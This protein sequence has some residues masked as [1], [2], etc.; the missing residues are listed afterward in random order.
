MKRLGFT[1]TA[2]SLGIGLAALLILGVG[3]SAA[4]ADDVEATP[5]T[6]L[7]AADGGP[8]GTAAVTTTFMVAGGELHSC[9]ITDQGGALQC[10]G[11]NGLGQ[12]GD[13]STDQHEAPVGVNGLSS[14]IR[15]VDGGYDHSCAVTTGGGVKCWGNNSTGQ[16]GNGYW[17]QSLVPVDVL[18]DD[19]STLG[20]AVAVGTGD[21]HSCA[22][23]GNGQVR[24]WGWNA[25]GQLGDNSF[26]NRGKA[27][28]VTTTTGSP[29]TSIQ[30]IDLGDVHSCALTTGGGVKC[31]GNGKYGKLGDGD[32]GVHYKMTPVDVIGLSG[33]ATISAGFD[34]TC[35]VLTDTTARCW[36]GNGSGQLGN[37]LVNTYCITPQ[38]VSG[39]TKG[40]AIAAGS[41]HTCA[42]LS[43]G[44]AKCWGNNLYGQLGDNRASGATSNVP[45]DVSGI[46][47]G[48]TALAIGLG[49]DHSC[50]I[51]EGWGVKCWGYNSNGQLGDDSDDNRNTPVNVDGLG[52]YKI[53]GSVLGCAGSGHATVSNGAGHTISCGATLCGYTFEDLASAAYT[54]TV[55]QAGYTYYPSQEVVDL[56]P[57][58]SDIDFTCWATAT[59]SGQVID[60]QGKAIPGVTMSCGSSP[61]TTT[62]S[63]GSFSFGVGYGSLGTLCELT[64]SRPGYRFSPA[65]RTVTVPPDSSGNDFQ[66]STSGP[67]YSISGQV[68]DGDGNPLGLVTVT[69]GG[70][71]PATSDGN[72]NYSL[73]TLVTGT[74]TF[75][76]TKTGFTFS[77]GSRSAGL[78]PDQSGQDFTATGQPTT[79]TIPPTGG[80]IQSPDSST[81]VQLPDG[82]VS[83]DTEVSFTP[84]ARWP[85]D[86][87]LSGTDHFFQLEAEQGGQP[88]SQFEQPVTITIE[89]TAQSVGNVDPT[90]LMLYWWNGS[91][92]TM[93]GI[94][95]VSHSG[96]T[97]TFTTTHTGLF[98]LLGEPQLEDVYLPVILR[99]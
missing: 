62:G 21:K 32:G 79:R 6:A 90:T 45:V 89:Y 93:Q 86:S 33:V 95:L 22:L 77:P 15:A 72:G 80:Q 18:N 9:A 60:G 98:A 67:S 13:N 96:D 59:V 84:Q 10:W 8:I 44:A 65:S 49:N 92:W 24:C 85:V 25:S 30:A 70:G 76:P 5:A 47:S 88:L 23:L 36:G 66:G 83:A 11:G 71:V 28:V 78:P 87:G 46:G 4:R 55:T 40:V 42:L 91:Q 75:T 20:G 53:E 68:A 26:D 54:V 48:S 14:G 51:F 17:T 63:D 31:W 29:L 37:G 81:T 58:A 69:E 35:A 12:L 7:Q 52:D 38:M 39:L 64:P 19:D 50:A 94:T 34:H 16:L 82:A 74:Y 43:T 73:T 3:L 1:A 2:L 61:Q 41:E 99:H 97:I 56:P 27:V 57:D